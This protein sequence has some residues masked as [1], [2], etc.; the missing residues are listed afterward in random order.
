MKCKLLLWLV[1]AF[2]LLSGTSQAAVHA[3]VSSDRIAAGDTLELTLAYDGQVSS[4]PDTGP[5]A[6]DFDVLSTSR[7][8]SV[9]IVNGTQ[10]SETELKLTLSPKRTGQL[11]IPALTWQSSQSA[12][13]VITVD[14]NSTSH[15]DAS[16]Q[17][18]FSNVFLE[19]TA[20]DSQ[21]YVQGAVKLTVKLYSGVHLSN[22]SLD[23]PTT[24]DVLIEQLGNDRNSTAELNG[25]RYNVIERDYL[26]FPQRSGALEIPGPIL[27]ARVPARS[28][29]SLFPHDS[30]SSLFD[31]S[32][33]AEMMQPMRSI[34]VR[35]DAI[36]L[37]VRPRP[38]L[39]TAS[40]WIPA[41]DLTVTSEW[42][43]DSL[44]VPVGE[45]ITL[46][47]RMRAEG[48]TAAQLPDIASIVRLP[49]GLNA[50][51]DQPKLENAGHDGTVIGTRTQSMALI[52]DHAGVF[53]IPATSIQWWDT[54]TD[55]LR[56]VEVPAVAI[57]AFPGASA[58]DSSHT[59][60]VVQQGALEGKN[61]ASSRTG[62]ALADGNRRQWLWAS[63][64]VLAAL[65]VGIAIR[66]RLVHRR[67]ALTASVTTQPALVRR[68]DAS[69]SRTAFLAACKVNDPNTARRA[70]LD[71]SQANWPDA[72]PLGLRNIAERIHDPAIGALLQDLDRACFVGG[73]WQGA[74][75]ARMLDRL[76]GDSTRKHAAQRSTLAALYP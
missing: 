57:K 69:R 37:N 34:R 68:L 29:S 72:P 31:E 73:H 62:A 59:N 65:A 16:S 9:R 67:S 54:R 10:S 41:K 64:V 23:F 7:S 33:F 25:H 19:T 49:P 20:D 30:F 56:T 63:F 5:L 32:P 8:T 48:L 28:N 53:E 39:A 74:E 55:Q 51:P 24:G 6:R 14:S 52:A 21:P 76:P 1:L 22:A 42:H 44:E 13:I 45:P 38:A 18:Q 71:W 26:L 11:T 40:Y 35:A 15:A 12:P 36:A 66:R 4:Q 47:L 75:L 58:N 46:D 50:Y 60:S 61:E 17:G 3:F 2:G 70:L 43:P 27:D